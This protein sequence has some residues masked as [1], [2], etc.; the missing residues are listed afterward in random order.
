MASQGAPPGTAFTETHWASLAWIGEGSY[1]F[2]MCEERPL[3]RPRLCT[4]ACIQVSTSG[5]GWEQ[6]EEDR[7]ILFKG[8]PPFII[9]SLGAASFLSAHDRRCHTRAVLPNLHMSL[10]CPIREPR[11]RKWVSLQ[12]FPPAVF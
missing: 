1:A 6:A 8:L 7:P 3:F 4:P 5:G 11:V 9:S 12:P 2:F 10:Y